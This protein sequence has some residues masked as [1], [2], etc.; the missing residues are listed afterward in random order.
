RPGRAD[1]EIQDGRAS[2]ASDGHSW[3]TDWG[4][5]DN[6]VAHASRHLVPAARI[7]RNRNAPAA[8]FPAALRRNAARPAAAGVRTGPV[9]A[10][11]PAGNGGPASPRTG[12]YHSQNPGSAASHRRRAI[13]APDQTPGGHA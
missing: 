12:R 13:A 3:A 10:P 5:A 6:G 8:G 9:R 11:S 2:V 7:R 1:A 4:T